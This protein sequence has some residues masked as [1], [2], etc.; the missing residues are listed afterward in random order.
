MRVHIIESGGAVDG[1]LNHVQRK[2]RVNKLKGYYCSE[3]RYF[4]A[5][6]IEIQ[7]GRMGNELDEVSEI[8]HVA[9]IIMDK[10]DGKVYTWSMGSCMDKI[11]LRFITYG[12]T[13]ST[14]ILRL[15]NLQSD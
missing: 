11:N 14:S 6:Q 5:S 12:S 10:Q 9:L 7:V 4:E 1:N 8:I 3:W 13:P 2:V 15:E